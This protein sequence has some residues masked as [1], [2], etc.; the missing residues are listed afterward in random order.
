MTATILLIVLFV[1]T[2]IVSHRCYFYYIFKS[3]VADILVQ[4]LYLLI[5]IFITLITA[6]MYNWCIS[7]LPGCWI[8]ISVLRLFSIYPEEENEDNNTENDN[9]SEENEQIDDDNDGNKKER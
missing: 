2:V 6:I 9:N 8:L 1:Y 5:F 7:V 3:Y 4:I